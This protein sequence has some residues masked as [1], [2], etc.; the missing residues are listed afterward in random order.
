MNLGKA[1]VS[2]CA[3]RVGEN[4]EREKHNEKQGGIL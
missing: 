3:G 4:G 1:H 2:A